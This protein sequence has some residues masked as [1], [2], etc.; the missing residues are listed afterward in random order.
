MDTI[1]R[2]LRA[3]YV[4]EPLTFEHIIQ[5]LVVPRGEV[6]RAKLLTALL[7]SRLIVWFAFHGTA[8]FGSERPK[9]L[10]TELLR[11]PFPSPENMPE[12]RRS[13]SAE[14]ALVALIDQQVDSADGS[15]GLQEDESHVFEEIDRLTYQF[16][17]LSDEEITL[18]DDT[19]EK[20]IPSIQ[21]RPSL[22]SDLWKPADPNDRRSY[23]A[24]LVRSMVECFDPGCTVSIRLEA[25]NDDLAV[26]RLT[27]EEGPKTARY[28]EEDDSSVGG[29]LANLFE[30][31]HQPLP[32]NFQLMPDFRIFAGNHLYLVKPARRR[33]WLRSA[34]LADADAIALDLQDASARNRRSLT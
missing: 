19:V 1:G 24:T 4:E 14:N 5:A 21:P 6:R 16:F 2:R 30:H 23:A 20:I 12:R 10:Q 27:L 29:V 17:C 8:S 11:L 32:G 28:T 3:A 31:I 15:F 9:V 34:A 7:N 22:F 13:E 18:V 25:R 26:L 33:F